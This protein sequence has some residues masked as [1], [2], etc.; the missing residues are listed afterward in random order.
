M[1]EDND[2]K[3][4]TG[5]AT[6][7][8]SRKEIRAPQECARAVAHAPDRHRR[9]LPQV[10]THHRWPRQRLPLYAGRQPSHS[11]PVGDRLEDAVA[12]H[13]EGVGDAVGHR[14]EA[15]RAGG[16]QGGRQRL[17]RRRENMGRL[18]RGRPSPAHGTNPRETAAGSGG[19]GRLWARFGGG[20]T[21]SLEL[22]GPK[23]KGRWHP[24]AR[25]VRMAMPCRPMQGAAGGPRSAM[26]SAGGR[27]M[28]RAQHATSCCLGKHN[29][30][31]S[32]GNQWK[33]ALWAGS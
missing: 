7:E 1:Q 8:L 28:R 5:S 2:G 19:G 31:G 18:R 22:H 13:V 27:E 9:H 15:A 30:R 17:C 16:R 4:G 11:C 24:V 21:S 20:A 10:S 33:A 32:K 23:E 6:R 3:D 25:G 12:D 26:R 29:G 14:D